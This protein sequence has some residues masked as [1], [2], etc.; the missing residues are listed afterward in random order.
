MENAK[1]TSAN[2]KWAITA[3]T[4]GK[5]SW[6]QWYLEARKE[7]RFVRL[8]LCGKEGEGDG[9]VRD[10]ARFSSLLEVVPSSMRD[11]SFFSSTALVVRP[12]S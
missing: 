2:G 6:D 8:G 11:R 12:F 4:V 7:T 5:V 10:E 9:D 3:V 1:G